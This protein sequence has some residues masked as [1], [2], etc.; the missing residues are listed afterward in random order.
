MQ[1]PSPSVQLLHPVGWLQMF[2][3]L[4]TLAW[5]GPASSPSATPRARGTSSSSC[6]SSSLQVP[7]VSPCYFLL[8][9]SDLPFTFRN[10][11]RMCTGLTRSACAAITA[12]MSLYAAGV[13]SSVS[14]VL[15]HSTPTVAAACSA[16][17]K[18]RSACLRPMAL[19]APCE[20]VQKDI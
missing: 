2:E 11:L 18:V 15:S 5:D 6:L 8:V 9:E 14:A 19:P 4:P 12:S 20:H 13:S 1:S 7:Q 16:T 10:C 3:V 17:V